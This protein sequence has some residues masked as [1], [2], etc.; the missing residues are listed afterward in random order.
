ML[1]DML[2]R[3]STR[4]IDAATCSS[5]CRAYDGDDSSSNRGSSSVSY[6]A[7]TMIRN[8][9]RPVTAAGS[10]SCFGRGSGS[11]GSGSRGGSSHRAGAGSLEV[12]GLLPREAVDTHPDGMP[13]AMVLALL[14]Q[15]RRT[16]SHA[17]VVEAAAHALVAF[18]VPPR[19]W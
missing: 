16:S 17:L 7:I 8:L 15:L 14:V 6:L 13:T 4:A 11:G 5:C 2:L 9:I 3:M 19:R 1:V 10:S 18:G 12:D